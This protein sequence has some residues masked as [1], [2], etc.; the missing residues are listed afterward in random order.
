[1]YVILQ[2]RW[3]IQSALLPARKRMTAHDSQRINQNFKT[4]HKRPPGSSADNY[5]REHP[6]P[7]QNTGSQQFR[8][9]SKPASDQ[10]LN[11]HTPA[12]FEAPMSGWF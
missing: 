5:I 11:I 10:L 12:G 2:Q 4:S 6:K 3:P 8:E 1:M 9:L 7:N